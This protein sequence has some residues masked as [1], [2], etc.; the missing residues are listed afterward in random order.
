MG[1]R[2]VEKSSAAPTVRAPMGLPSLKIG[3]K[4]SRMRAK[5]STSSPIPRLFVVAALRLIDSDTGMA[6]RL[7]EG[8][9]KIVALV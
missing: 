9:I 1:S 5:T 3:H 8:T 6:L 2:R 4:A 7:K